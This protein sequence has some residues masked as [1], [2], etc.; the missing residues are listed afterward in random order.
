[1]WH[2]LPV[3]LSQLQSS[4]KGPKCATWILICSH[5]VHSDSGKLQGAHCKPEGDLIELG[6]DDQN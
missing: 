6:P 3:L 1:M 4:T 2:S 5:S